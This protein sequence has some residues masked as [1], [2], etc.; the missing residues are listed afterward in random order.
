[1]LS[2]I[3]T[4]DTSGKKFAVIV[5]DL[6]ELNI[7]E[8]LIIPHIKKQDEQLIELSNGCICCTLREDLL[9]EVAN[10][11]LQNRFDYLLI[12]STGISEP[13]PVAETF[14]FD[15]IS[16]LE[17]SDGSASLNQSL[18]DLAVIDNMVTV[19]DAFNFLRHMQ[20]AEDLAS[21]NMQAEEGDTRTITDLLVSQIEFA[22]VIVLNKI[23]MVDRDTVANIKKTLR[24]LNGD[25]KIIEATRSDVALSEIIDTGNYDFDKVSNSPTWIKAMNENAHHEK[26]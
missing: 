14:T 6:S 4:K 9:R 19:V 20:E 26:V 5:N 17:A 12:E 22:N 2:N 15:F 24:A 11:A 21:L 25:A 18:V 8:K 10:L 1:M 23:D 13:L 7:D 16:N 3:L